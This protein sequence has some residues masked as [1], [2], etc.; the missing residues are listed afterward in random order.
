M[1]VPS[2]L[3]KEKKWKLVWNDE[4]DGDALD[5]SK[6][7]FRRHL[8]HREYPPFTDEGVSVK[9]SCLYISLVKKGDQYAS[10]H[11]QTGEN[12][13]DR[14]SESSDWPIAPFSTPKF[15][16]KYGYYECRCK[17]PMGN[18]WW[19]AFWLQS[20][21]IGCCADPAKAGVE[22]DIMESFSDYGVISRETMSHNAHWGGYGKDHRSFGLK[23][24]TLK[25]TDDDF[26]V[27]GVDWSKDGYRFYVDGELS[28]YMPGPVSDTEQFILISTEC[29]GYRRTPSEPCE[30]LKTNPLPDAFVVDYVRVYDEEA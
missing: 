28:A 16:H 19:A 29:N 3:P 22:V 18:G 14:P 13:I 10:A 11:L 27:Y 5:E 4:F 20:P 17:L 21:V 2:L 8:F 1:M 9:E 30:E 15:M 25:P 6:W 7:S 23:P 26:H 24:Y 12:Y